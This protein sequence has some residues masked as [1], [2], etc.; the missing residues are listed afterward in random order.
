ML[1]S[2]Y[3]VYG[4]LELFLSLTVIML[5]IMITRV[6]LYCF[7]AVIEHTNKVIFLEDDD[8]AAVTADGGERVVVAIRYLRDA[9]FMHAL[10]TCLSFEEFSQGPLV[11]YLCVK[12]CPS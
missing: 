3:V 4:S 1:I 9:L 5:C 12:V 8:V 6:C 11:N 10:H 7:S 2:K